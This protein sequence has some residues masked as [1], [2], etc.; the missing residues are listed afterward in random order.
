MAAEAAAEAALDASQS[1]AAYEAAEVARARSTADESATRASPPC[2]ELD[3]SE[4]SDGS[5]SSDAPSIANSTQ[6]APSRPPSALKRPTSMRTPVPPEQQKTVRWAPQHELTKR[7][8][9]PPVDAFEN[10]PVD[11]FENRPSERHPWGGME[12]EEA[13]YETQTSWDASEREDLVPT[14][15]Q[16]DESVPDDEPKKPRLRGM[17]SMMMMSS[18]ARDEEFEVY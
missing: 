7:R 12:E 11:R 6:T 13:M 2:S 17:S 15:P 8:V 10:R 16:V 18:K 1:E 9:L 3:G 14:P 5:E 4:C